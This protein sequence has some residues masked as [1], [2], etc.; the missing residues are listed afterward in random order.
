MNREELNCE[1]RKIAR[2]IADDPTTTYEW[3]AAD[4]LE[5]DVDAV[6]VV[7]GRWEPS[8]YN[9]YCRCSECRDCFIDKTWT[10]GGKWRYCPTCGAMMDGGGADGQ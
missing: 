9:G 7:H 8:D 4:M 1:L 10:I 6:P 5:A 2:N 3:A